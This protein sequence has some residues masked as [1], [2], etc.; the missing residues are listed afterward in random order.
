MSL[1]KSSQAGHENYLYYNSGTVAVPV[2]V[3]IPRASDVNANLSK[4]RGTSARR[5]SKFKF[6]RGGQ[7]GTEIT[8]Q[9]VY[10]PATDT[11]F[12]ALRG[13]FLSGTP[14]EFA[15]M[16]GD[17]TAASST[18]RGWRAAYEVFDFNKVSGNN[19]VV[20]YD[21]TLGITDADDELD[22]LVEPSWY[23]VV[24]P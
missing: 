18:I 11:V 13:S 14:Y 24:N 16:D 2:W 12:A 8:F 10:K 5:G 1:T 22:A 3:E 6:E 20:V 17:I 4:E 9:Y 21:V 19:D 15:E 23:E 7:V